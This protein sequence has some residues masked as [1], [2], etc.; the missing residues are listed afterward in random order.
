MT[1]ALVMMKG[2]PQTRIALKEY[3]IELQGD[4]KFQEKNGFEIEKVMLSFGWPDYIILVHSS[5]VELIQNCIISLQSKIEEIDDCISTSTIIC[6][7]HEEL[8]KKQK[9]WAEISNF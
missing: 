5:N 9:E 6:T 3:L 2:L 1:Y 8:E 7:T 4:K